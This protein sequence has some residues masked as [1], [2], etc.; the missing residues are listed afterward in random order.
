EH[1]D[2]EAAALDIAME[3]SAVVKPPRVA[4]SPASIECVLDRVVEVGKSWLVLGEVKAITVSDDAMEDGRPQMHLLRPLSRLGGE[5]WGRPPEV[6]RLS[7]PQ[8]VD[9]V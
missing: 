1:G 8:S 5:E 2:D 3:P 9:D 7:R 6:F 4:H